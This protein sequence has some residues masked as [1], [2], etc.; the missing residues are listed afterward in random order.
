[1]KSF[2][3]EYGEPDQVLV[4]ETFDTALEAKQWEEEV[5]LAIP[6]EHRK[7][8]WL[9][10]RF[11]SFKNV[12]MTKEM[13]AK[14]A[15]TKRKNGTHKIGAMKAAE[16]K[17]KNGTNKTGAMKAVET[18]LKNGTNKTGPMK[19]AETKRKNGTNKTGAMKAVETKRKNGT[20]KIGAMK[21][22]ETRRK[23]GT[24][25]T[26]AIKAAETKRKNGTYKIGAMKAAETKRKN[27]EYELLSIRMSKLRKDNPDWGTTTGY[28]NEYRAEHG[29]KTIPGKPRGSKEK[30]STRKK[31]SEARKGKSTYK[32]KEGD[33][34]VCAKDDPRVLSGEY[35]SVHRGSKY[36]PHTEEARKKMSE[37]AKNRPKHHCDVCGRDIIVN[38]WNEHLQSQR[39]AFQLS[40]QN[41]SSDAKDLK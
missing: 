9:N 32:N 15:E 26:G 10:L 8:Y 22:A 5:L 18:R 2:R 12:V 41:Q 31:K 36:Q 6:K 24:N 14:S 35:W 17:R 1:V 29:M 37:I 34:I 38:K 19:A 28:T 4:C 25:K 30:E 7:L 39:H 23:N 13:I 21:A 16:T 27:G 33:C 11:G 20:H 40:K 3:E